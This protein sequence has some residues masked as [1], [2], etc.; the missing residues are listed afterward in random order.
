MRPA[1]LDRIPEFPFHRL[2]AL[3]DGVVPPADADPLALSIGEPRHPPPPMIARVLEDQAGLWN[4]YPP[5]DGTPEFRRAVAGWLRRRYGLDAVDE[6]SHVLCSAGSRESLYLAAA[7][8]VSE[9]EG[10]PEP[11]ALIPNPHYHVYAGAAVMAGAEPRFLP[12][13][14]DTGFLPDLSALDA[15]TLERTVIAYLCTPA[16]PQGAVAG[17]DYLAAWVRLARDHG[18]LL[19]VDE[20]YAEIYCGRPPP[21][22]LQAAAPGFEN[23]LAFHSLSKRSSAAGL[24]S[25]FVAGDAALAA[26]FKHLRSYGGASLPMPVMAASAALWGDED[27]VEQNRVLY[28]AKFDL[29][30]DMLDGRYG[31]YRPAGGFF[32]WLRVGDGE[33]AARRLWGEAGLRVMPGAYMAAED[34]GLNPGAPYIRLALVDDTDTLGEALNRLVKVLR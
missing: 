21:G 8:A 25:G 31:F 11:L 13:T 29:A 9:F 33:A 16:N 32:L 4:R 3:L 12:A 26:K 1:M 17:L 28:R 34:G 2:R 14:E 24:R 10:G 23:V 15:E 20:C 5:I 18:F 19:A 22:A 7:L 30:A 27:H 6:D